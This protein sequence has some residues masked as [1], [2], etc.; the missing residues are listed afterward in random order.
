MRMNAIIA[1]VGMTKFGKHLDRGMKSIGAEAVAA[2][3]LDA[4]LDKSDLE[5]AYVGNAA[6]GLV[7]GQECIRGQV[8]LR[9]AGIGRIPVINVENACASASTAFN[10]A[11]A[12][13]SS[14]CYE[15]VLA[16]GVEKL[17]HEDKRKSFAAFSGAVDVEEL[18]EIKARLAQEAAASGASTAAS[19]AGEKRSMF[20]DFYAAS[21][22]AY[23]EK[24]GA[25]AADLA[26]VSAKNSFH[27][28]LNPRAQFMDELSVEEVLAAPMIAEPLTRPMCSPIGDGAAAVVLVSERKARELGFAN[29]VRVAASVLRSGWDRAEDEETV[30]EVCAH[31]AYEAAGAGPEDLSVIELH[32]ASAPAEITTYEKL[33]LCG[34]GQ[35]A[36]LIRDGVT[37]LGGRLP[38]N[39]SGGLLRKGHPVGATGIAQIVE[40]TEQLQ[41]RSGERQVEGARMA[42]AHN[43]GGSLGSDAAAMC[44][45]ILNR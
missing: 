24:Y 39:T 2:A 14:G 20:M 12:M 10:Q 31:E 38:V 41:G 17:Y 15:V 6:A 30:A 32:D 45:T 43:G 8:V 42:L 40:L 1:G 9:D 19:G 29:P 44:V 7:T 4:G 22:R 13:V 5:A 37:K 11:S 23:M 25:T 34:E 18:V 33:G 35:G 21:A 28:S 36:A 27:G 3:L 16:L 26:G